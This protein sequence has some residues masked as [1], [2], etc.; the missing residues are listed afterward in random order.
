MLLDMRELGWCLGTSD[1]SPGLRHFGGWVGVGSSISH[2]EVVVSV[3]LLRWK[4]VMKR[5]LEC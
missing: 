1:D 4:L 3:Y 5:K 2:F